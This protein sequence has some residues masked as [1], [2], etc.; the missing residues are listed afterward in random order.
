[1]GWIGYHPGGFELSSP[2]QNMAEQGDDATQTVTTWDTAGNVTGTRAYTAAETAAM[3]A[4]QQ[5]QTAATNQATARTNLQ[6][7][8]GQQTTLSNQLQAD[9]STVQTTGW[10]ALTSTQRTDIM[11][12]ILQEGLAN[13]MQAIVDH[14][15]VNGI[16]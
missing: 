14:L 7:L 13:A 4:A 5:A 16:T 3:Q 12:R 2:Q 15:T 8:L 6:S 9:I 1:M 10:D 11:V